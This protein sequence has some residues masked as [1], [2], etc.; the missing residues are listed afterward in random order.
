MSSRLTRG[1]IVMAVGLCLF[2]FQ[3]CA[4]KPPE[5]FSA[6]VFIDSDKVNQQSLIVEINQALYYSTTLSAQLEVSVIDVN[7]VGRVF[8]GTIDY[9]L[10]K[11]GE[12]VGKYLPGGLPYLVCLLGDK[13]IH[14]QGLYQASEI[15]ECTKQG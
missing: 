4:V 9:R 13:I 2:C 11:T 15:R 12:W 14:K 6:V 8:N 5:R 1:N 10:D 7:P 3:A